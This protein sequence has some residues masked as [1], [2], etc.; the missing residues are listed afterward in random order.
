MPAVVGT[1]GIV[2]KDG[3]II[4]QRAH[5]G[6]FVHEALLEEVAR[7]IPTVARD[8]KDGDL[9]ACAPVGQA[10]YLVMD[11]QDLLSSVR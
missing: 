7:E 6:K 8:P 9:L 4:A 1:A 11:D 10:D 5:E 2:G 3:V